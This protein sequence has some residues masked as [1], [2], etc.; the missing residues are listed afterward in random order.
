MF[1]TGGGHPPAPPLR[2]PATV[3]HV[4]GRL[5]GIDD[6]TRFQA[7]LPFPSQRGSSDVP[8]CTGQLPPVEDAPIDP[9]PLRLSLSAAHVKLT[10]GTLPKIRSPRNSFKPALLRSVEKLQ[11]TPRSGERPRM[12]V[13]QAR[14]KYAYFGGGKRRRM[15]ASS[16]LEYAR[17]TNGDAQDT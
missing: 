12:A 4:D 17:R 3:D 5:V 11:S 1:T 6:W 16:W 13:W 9:S 8:R 2:E 10:N 14:S 15:A 7:Y